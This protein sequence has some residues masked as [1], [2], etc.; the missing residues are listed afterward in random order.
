MPES[1]RNFLG[2]PFFTRG[3]IEFKNRFGS[4]DTFKMVAD[5]RKMAVPI[6]SKCCNFVY[7]SRNCTKFEAQGELG[8]S[9]DLS[10]FDL[11]VTSR[12]LKMCVFFHLGVSGC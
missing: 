7:N 5:Q 6:F 10:Y 3:S 11:G 4:T 1:Y 2:Q 8:G 12:D 9:F